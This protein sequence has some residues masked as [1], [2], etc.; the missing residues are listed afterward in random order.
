M[1]FLPSSVICRR[2][3]QHGDGDGRSVTSGVSAG[4]LRH[5]YLRIGH[6]APTGLSPKLVGEFDD[7]RKTGG[8]HRMSARL[9]PAAGVDR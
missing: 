8:R 1:P 6:L 9:Q 5:A 2:A 3:T 7:L 4:V